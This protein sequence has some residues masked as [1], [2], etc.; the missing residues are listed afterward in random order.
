MVVFTGLSSVW[1]RTLFTNSGPIVKRPLSLLTGMNLQIVS[2]TEVNI[3]TASFTIS[4]I[5]YQ[6][7]IIGSPGGRN[8][9]TFPIGSIVS[10]T[11]VGLLGVNF[12]ITNVSVTTNRII[13]LVN[14]IRNKFTAHRT[15]AGVHGT[16]DIVNI[17]VSG[18]A[19]DLASAILLMNEIKLR[20]NAHAVLITG[21][22]PVHLHP[23]TDSIVSY[24][25][26]TRLASAVQLINELRDKYE[27]HRKNKYAH[28]D[29]DIQNFVFASRVVVFKNSGPLTGPFTW[30]LK[31]PLLGMVA[32]HPIDVDVRVNSL[33]ALVDAVYGLLGAVVLTTKPNPTDTVEIDYNFLN[34]PPA[35]LMRLNSPEFNLNQGG[36]KGYAGYP[37]H[38]YRSRSYLLNPGN[39]PDLMSAI[40]PRKVGWKYKGYERAYTAVL[41]DP[42]TLL[43]NVP[44]NKISFPVLFQIISETIIRYDPTTLP[45]NATDPWILEGDGILTLTSGGNDLSITDSNIQTGPTSMPPF[46]TH[47]VDIKTTSVISA[48]FRAKIEKFVSD[49][50][51]T[52]IS[53]GISDGQKAAITAFLVTNATNLSSAIVMANDLRS[54]FEAHLTNLGS[55][56]PN[57]SAGVIPVVNATNLTSLVILINEIKLKFNLHLSKGG[58]VG[59]VHAVVDLVNPVV[60]PDAF[61]LTSALV[62]TNVLRANFNAH[63]IQTSIHFVNDDTNV[64]D[65]VKQVGILT[66]SGYAEFET[67]WES[68]AADWTEYKTY[69]IYRDTTGD[70]F[71][72]L[73]A[74]AVPIAT[75]DYANLPAISNIDGKFDPVQQVFFGPIGR[76]STSISHWQFIRTTIMPVDANLIGD[77][78]AIDYTADITPELDP[79]A[80]WITI[81]QGGYERILAG[82]TLLVDSTAKASEGEVAALG[83]SSGA[84]RGYTRLEPILSINTAASVEFQVSIDYYTFGLDN[85]SAGVFI[86]DKSLSTQLLFLQY[87]PSA[88]TV[89]G[90]AVQLFPMINGDTVVFRINGIESTATFTNVDITANLVCNKINAAVGFLF[91]T[92]VGGQ[93]RLTSQNLGVTATFEILSG[94]ALSK[95]GFSPGTYIGLDS[96]PDPKVSWFGAN[97]PDED[98]PIWTVS[99][100]QSATMLGRVLRLSDTSVS[101]Y[102]SYTLS[103]PVVTNDAFNPLIDWKLDVRLSMQTFIAG[104]FVPVPPGPFIALR[105]AGA[106]VSVDEGFTGKNLELHLAIDPVTNDQYLNLL[107]YDTITGILRV[108]AQYAFAWNDNHIHSFN[109]YTAKAIDSVF[110]YADGVP[111]VSLG[112]VLSYAGLN[113]GILGGPSISFG[114]GGDPV[115]GSDLRTAESV[116]DWESV[117]IFKDS[118]ISDPTAASRRFIGIYKGGNP[119]YLSSY[120]LHQIDWTNTHVYRIVRDPTTSVSV[121]VDGGVVPV[122]AVPYDVLTLPPPNTDIINLMSNGQPSI[123]FG[124]FNPEEITRTRWAYVRYSMGKI[125]LDERLILPHQ[126]ENQLNVVASAEHLYTQALH[127]HFGFK[128][129]S[130]GTPT[131]DFM[132]DATVPAYTQLNEGTPPVPMTQDLNCRAGLRKTATVI[133]TIPSVDVVNTKG[134]ITDLEDDTTNALVLGPIFDLN[135]SIVA[136][137]DFRTKYLAHVIQY[138]VHV[139]NDIVN[140]VLPLPP[141]DLPTALTFVNAA[142]AAFNAHRTAIVKETQRVHTVNDTVNAVVSP[143]AGDPGSLVTLTSE[144]VAKYELHRVQSGIH[145]ASVF[146][147]L[148]PPS[149]VLYEGMKFWQFPTGDT[150]HVSPVSDDET[151]SIDGFKLQGETRFDYDGSDLPEVIDPN[152]QILDTNG[153]G[154][155]IV[156]LVAG[157]LRYGTDALGVSTIYRNDTPLPD[158]TRDFELGVSLKINSY[159]AGSTLD[160]DIYAGFLSSIGPGIAA[161]VGF[162]AI[163]DIPYVKIQ[164]VNNNTTIYRVPFNWAD[165]A[166]HTYRLV[167]DVDTNTIGLI[168]DS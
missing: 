37:Q 94:S 66:N 149:R 148:D 19:V 13:S 35:R 143:D 90:T 84:Y 69:R 45:Q 26:A 65:L 137:T 153:P 83:L 93:I 132:S 27:L 34:N 157:A 32:D 1:D 151:W 20:L 134:N 24:Q 30:Y 142:K 11:R 139:A 28:L 51:F 166:S 82:N 79:D 80:P 109:I 146:I 141:T 106:L 40:Q 67:S 77:N 165:G 29:D 150:G 161:A 75:V 113:A 97:R 5:G 167:Y 158:T 121:Y 156:S 59:A 8:D 103:D 122:I 7:Q 56:D 154:I 108:V 117:A 128:S 2:E 164:D 52:G 3:P 126:V 57:D 114:S 118:K 16:N 71:L 43:L 100:A 70:I 86:E 9:G 44:T 62:L 163:N 152:W 74:S 127:T 145:G 112:P 138:R 17:I 124:S 60:T 105:F 10:P 6:I 46:F 107:S 42:T 49:G 102:I 55:H 136:L 54:K 101:D 73:S 119:T 125:T 68:Y 120:Y 63:R 155:A 87:S 31:N 98:D 110:V 81:G 12:D 123:S 38:R 92:D 23:D 130:G 111:L 160:T 168:I 61:D 147:R 131:D 64:V 85:K 48:A 144:I 95:L 76:E 36:N 129:Y 99:G 14:D 96:N 25:D 33:P 135:S 22:P 41:N 15:A 50:A 140:V 116:V 58:G 159:P 39:S 18:P 21:T 133:E 91:A 47:A 72:Y 89:L 115:T 162:D 78:K 88:A 104:D 4:N 53:F